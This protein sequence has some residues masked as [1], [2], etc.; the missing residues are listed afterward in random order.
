M[1]LI[2]EEKISGIDAHFRKY[3]IGGIDISGIVS[4]ITATAFSYSVIIFSQN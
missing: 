2:L 1:A 3:H 4:P